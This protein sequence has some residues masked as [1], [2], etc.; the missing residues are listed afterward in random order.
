[1]VAAARS[2][3]LKTLG[4]RSL[5]F[6][7]NLGYPQSMLARRSLT[8][9]G[10][11]RV[12]P[13]PLPVFERPKELTMNR[14]GFVAASAFAALAAATAGM[15]G[16]VAEA[17]KRR[18]LGGSAFARAQVTGKG[19]RVSVSVNCGAKR[20]ASDAADTGVA[21]RG[22]HGSDGGQSSGGDGSEVS[23]RC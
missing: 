20:Q 23:E 13:A 7:H 6:S 21:S 19:G 8:S 15:G 5:E 2:G 3:T 1:M 22:G 10:T 11:M 16:D 18:N 17:R 9:S 14:R 12:P 4:R